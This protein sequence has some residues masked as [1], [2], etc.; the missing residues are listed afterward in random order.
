V[1]VPTENGEIVEAVFFEVNTIIF[2]IT[3]SCNFLVQR[4]FVLYFKG[5]ILKY[6]IYFCI[7]ITSKHLQLGDR[8]TDERVQGAQ[9]AMKNAE[10]LEGFISKID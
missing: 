4:F 8:L 2:D 9:M 3:F 10:R 7:R 6:E 5:S 1:Y